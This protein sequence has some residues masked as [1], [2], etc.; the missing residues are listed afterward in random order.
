MFRSFFGLAKVLVC[1]ILRLFL[2]LVSTKCNGNFVRVMGLS[3]VL[4]N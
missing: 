3:F 4:D 2:V 1:I